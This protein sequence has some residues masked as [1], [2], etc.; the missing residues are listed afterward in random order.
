M[1]SAVEGLEL[2]S[3]RLL[4]LV[5]IELSLAFFGIVGRLLQ[6]NFENLYE[7]LKVTDHFV[8]L[9]FFHNDYRTSSLHSFHLLS[10]Y[11]HSISQ[12]LVLVIDFLHVSELEVSL[13]Q[14]VVQELDLLFLPDVLIIK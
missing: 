10:K 12:I 6:L 3:C 11:T 1:K 8:I 13:D 7:P 4:W 14:V 9:G 2:R 5:W